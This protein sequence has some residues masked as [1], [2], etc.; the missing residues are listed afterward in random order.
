MMYKMK[1]YV[2]LFGLFCMILSDVV[3]VLSCSGDDFVIEEN[4]Q[5]NV[6]LIPRRRSMSIPG[7][8]GPFDGTNNRIDYPRNACG[9]WSIVS[10]ISSPNN[11]YWY[12]K[13]YTYACQVGWTPNTDGGLTPEQIIQVCDLIRQNENLKSE[14][15]E[16][17]PQSV[18]DDSAS[19]QQY[20]RTLT[21]VPEDLVVGVGIPEYVYD[22]TLK[23]D[24]LKLV[25]HWVPV[26]KISGSIVTVRNQYKG[27]ES[28]PRTEFHIDEIKCVCY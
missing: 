21:T 18:E 16:R 13:V 26:V 9:I 7:E 23:R 28:K 25:D 8:P 12:N 2:I 1:K 10:K 4:N 24:V 15:L 27:C 14:V 17:L 11:S 5:E 19:A 22:S 20:L 3:L 6:S